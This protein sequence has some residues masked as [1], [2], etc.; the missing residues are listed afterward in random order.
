MKEVLCHKS[1]DSTTIW[2]LSVVQTSAVLTDEVVIK[3]ANIV[4]HKQE[5]LQMRIVSTFNEH[6]NETYLEFKPMKNPEIDFE[7]VTLSTRE[8]WPVVVSQDNAKKKFDY[9]NGPLWRCIL[10]RIE[11]PLQSGDSND[12]NEVLYEHII[13]VKIL[14]AIADGVSGLDF[15]NRQFLPVLSA[16]LKGEDAVNIIPFRPFSKPVESFFLEQDAVPWYIKLGAD[17]FRWINRKFKF[18]GALQYK[19]PD[20]ILPSADEQDNEP[21]YVSKVFSKEITDTIILSAKNNGAKLHC[22][23]LFA[24]VLAFCRT[25]KSAGVPIPNSL[26]QMWPIDLR[27]YIGYRTPQPLACIVHACLTTHQCMTTCTKEEFWNNCKK[28]LYSVFAETRKEKIVYGLAASK[29]LLDASQ[30]IPTLTV[31]LELGFEPKILLSNAGKIDTDPITRTNDGAT[32]VRLTE[33]YGFVNGS[34]DPRYIPILQYVLTYEGKF[35]WTLVRSRGTSKRF[36]DT[37]LQNLEE[38]LKYYSMA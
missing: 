21:R 13:F 10:G 27:R 34:S 25:A 29:Y 32:I 19:F 31:L 8:A 35:M 33:Q 2:I 23:L 20:E 4:M 17:V 11:L 14:H 5:A 18:Q 9:T 6:T 15:I 24:G 7:A 38:V 16:L 22:V 37:Y 28:L 3:A 12:P 26:Q 36:T 30:S 1:A